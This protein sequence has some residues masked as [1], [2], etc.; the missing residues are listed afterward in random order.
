MMHI[1]EHRMHA[2]GAGHTRTTKQFYAWA[3]SDAQTRK[4]V[5]DDKL[6]HKRKKALR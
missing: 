3:H 6:T 2:H 5:D 4:I 1:D